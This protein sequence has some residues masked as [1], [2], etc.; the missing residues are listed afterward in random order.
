[1]QYVYD[2]QAVGSNLVQTDFSYTRCTVLYSTLT[3]NA[4]PLHKLHT[5]TAMSRS[6]SYSRCMVPTTRMPL[7][8]A[9]G[10]SLA[11][12]KFSYTR[13]MVLYS[14]LTYHAVQSPQAVHTNWEVP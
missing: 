4:V 7:L 9:M 8:K 10:S 2:P 12:K 6:A 13:C 3:Y 5:Q 11:K 1:M 14:T